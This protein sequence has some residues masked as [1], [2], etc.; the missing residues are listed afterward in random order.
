MRCRDARTR[1]SGSLQSALQA[2]LQHS[3]RQCDHSTATYTLP[4]M[5]MHGHGHGHGHGRVCTA[6]LCTTQCSYTRHTHSRDAKPPVDQEPA[7]R[8]RRRHLW[9]Y[10]VQLTAVYSYPPSVS[11]EG[12]YLTALAPSVACVQLGS[13]A[14]ALLVYRRTLTLTLTLTLNL[15]L[16]LTQAAQSSAGRGSISMRHP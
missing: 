15:T 4:C 5:H 3:Q 6:V 2:P 11:W 1:R 8:H 16:T 10:C 9:R 12:L 13:G 7:N 14:A